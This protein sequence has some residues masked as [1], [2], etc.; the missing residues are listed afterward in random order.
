MWTSFLI[1]Y[2]YWTF[3]QCFEVTKNIEKWKKMTN[4]LVSVETMNVHCVSVHF[5]S[6]YTKSFLSIGN[7]CQ[8]MVNNMHAL[9]RT[10]TIGQ[11]ETRNNAVAKN[12]ITPLTNDRCFDAFYEGYLSW[13]ISSTS[14]E[15]RSSVGRCGRPANR[16]WLAAQINSPPSNTMF[17]RLNTH[18]N[19]A[20]ESHE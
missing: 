14:L 13:S 7:F 15:A 3:S 1:L 6:S 9:T 20:E 4:G 2:R 5:E 8:Y 16:P 17:L 12:W 10:N 11:H 19:K 18:H